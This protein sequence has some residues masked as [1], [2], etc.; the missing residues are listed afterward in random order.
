MSSQVVIFSL[1]PVQ[2]FISQARRTQDLYMGSQLL[3]WLA[4]QGVEAAEAAGARLVY[5]VRSEDKLPTSVPNRFVVIADDGAAMGQQIEEAVRGAWQTIADQAFETVASLTRDTTWKEIW[6]RQVDNW[7]ELYWTATPY[8]PEAHAE[9]LTHASRVMATRKL[10]RHFA[11]GGEAGWK[12]SVCGEREVLHGPSGRYED[13]RAYWAE[14]HRRVRPV[15]LLRENERLCAICA[16]KRFTEAFEVDSFPS[17][18]SIAAESFKAELQEH[19]RTVEDSVSILC[20]ALVALGV[21]SGKGDARADLINLDGEYLYPST[22]REAVF[23]GAAPAQVRDAER[24]LKKLFKAAGSAG[25]ARPHTYL[26]VVAIDGDRMG[27]LVG[28]CKLAKDHERLS[29]ALA[30]F[31]QYTVPEIVERHTGRLIY[32]GGDDVLALF[33]SR[34]ALPAADELRTAFSQALDAAGFSGHA[35]AGIAI[36]HHTHPL[37]AALESA[38]DA[39]KAAKNDLDRNAVV[40]EVVKRSG[41][42]ERVGAKWDYCYEGAAYST[43]ATFDDLRAAFSSGV[44]S[45]GLP[46][47]LQELAYAA[48]QGEMYGEARRAA[49][50]RLVSRRASGAAL[51]QQQTTLLYALG[52]GLDWDRMGLWAELARFIGQGGDS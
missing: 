30:H 29:S 17:T 52:E 7:L 44:L 26:A 31:A 19:W 49:L 10:A 24:A 21:L 2:Q 11:Q 27:R 36:V 41:E 32:A 4:Q 43:A 46:Y 5:P 25:I 12:C 35:S 38:R 8:R 39:E 45:R 37:G 13:V 48:P 1:G 51:V 50:M 15:T 20:E 6:Y 3:S 34:E 23:E 42:R 22:Y 18:S 14:I 16:I 9:S 28:Q 33:P 47:D 40:I